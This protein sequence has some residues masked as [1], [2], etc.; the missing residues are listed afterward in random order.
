VDLWSCIKHLS[1]DWWV[2]LGS[3]KS[4]VCVCVEFRSLFRDC[5]LVE[6]SYRAGL[7][8]FLAVSLVSKC[9]I[10]VVMVVVSGPRPVVMPLVPWLLRA[11]SEGP[12]EARLPRGL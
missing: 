1:V 4:V 12:C 3:G 7:L 5:V 8:S 9:G 10:R 2:W 6:V 11:V